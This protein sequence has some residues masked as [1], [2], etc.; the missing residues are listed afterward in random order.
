MRVAPQVVRHTDGWEVAS[1]G[2]ECV[3]YRDGVRE[4]T[5]GVGRG[6]PSRLYVD[7][8]PWVTEAG[9]APIP[10]PEQS[11][12]LVRLIEGMQEMGFP[13]SCTGRPSR[14]RPGRFPDTGCWTHVG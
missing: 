5:I 1:A 10:E 8:L 3:R 11:V 14:T 9:E 12:I 6:Q 2:R 4:A 13:W 7:S